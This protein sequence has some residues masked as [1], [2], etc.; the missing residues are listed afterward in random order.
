[1]IHYYWC[2]IWTLL[3]LLFKYI[4][5]WR[6][7]TTKTCLLTL[8]NIKHIRHQAL[9]VAPAS[10]IITC[11]IRQIFNSFWSLLSKKL[12]IFNH[13]LFKPYFRSKQN[14]FF[15]Y[16]SNLL[17]QT[18]QTQTNNFSTFL[19]PWQWHF[20]IHFHLNWIVNTNANDN[21]SVWLWLT[22]LPLFIS[23]HFISFHF[24]WIH[25]PKQLSP[26]KPLR[27]II[28]RKT[29]WNIFLADI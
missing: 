21:G 18:L 20:V 16:F 6:K 12:L 5:R 19:F 11:F 29:I 7:F 26:R 10:I 8:K 27:K 4:S 17:F 28:T 25:F 22:Q 3:L 14:F 24:I 15:V 2:W 13:L 23:F 1:M 9:I